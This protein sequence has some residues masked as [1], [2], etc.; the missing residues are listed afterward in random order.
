MLEN[1]SANI[2][3][4]AAMKSL[5]TVNGHSITKCAFTSILPHP[6]TEGDTIFTT[7][8]NF[9]DVLKQKQ[10]NSGPLWSDNGVYRIAKEIQLCQP[11]KF[12]NIFLGIGGFHL[13]KV[14]IGCL[15]AYLET[16]GIQNI[17]VEHEIFG[18]GVV[19]TVMNGGN[20]V[21]GKRGISLLAESMEQLQITAFLQQYDIEMFGGMSEK[22]TQLQSLMENPNENQERISELWKVCLVELDSFEHAFNKF[23][24]SDCEKSELFSYWNK[25]VNNSAPVFRDLT[26]SF[27]NGNWNLHMSAVYRAIPLC[28]AFDRINHKRWLPLYYEDCLALPKQFPEMYAAFVDADFVVIHSLR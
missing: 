19:N 20:Y 9:Q 15:G 3:S 1:G 5:L 4:F 17:F 18:P 7:M 14:I 2:P 22:I 6:A 26:R 16:S 13:E 28:F 27:R 10:L 11:D 12:S 25:F 23:K 8:I 24:M 21:R